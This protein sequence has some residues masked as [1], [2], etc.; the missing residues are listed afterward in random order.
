M[1]SRLLHA[2]LLFNLIVPAVPYIELAWA[3]ESWDT[4]MKIV[5]SFCSPLVIGVM[6]SKADSPTIGKE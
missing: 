2:L 5:L 3:M 1:Y 6:P 4:L